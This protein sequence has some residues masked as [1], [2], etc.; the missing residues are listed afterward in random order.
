MLNVTNRRQHT[1]FFNEE[2]CP[3]SAACVRFSHTSLAGLPRLAL[4]L[5][6]PTSHSRVNEDT[7]VGEQRGAA[8]GRGLPRK[9]SQ[10][11]YKQRIATPPLRRWRELNIKQGLAYQPTGRLFCQS[12]VSSF[13]GKSVWEGGVCLQQGHATFV[14]RPLLP[15][16]VLTLSLPSPKDFLNLS[17]FVR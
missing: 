14:T 15:P 1:S 6:V 17:C 16:V 13:Q 2:E 4:S 12:A 7:G 5:L 3:S 9:R 8:G 10:S 11:P